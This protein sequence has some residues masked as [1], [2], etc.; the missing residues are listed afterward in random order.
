MTEITKQYKDA[1]TLDGRLKPQA[2]VTK[3]KVAAVKGLVESAL[4]GSAISAGT[5]KETMTTSDAIFAFAYLTNLNFIPQYDAAPRT[6]NQVAGTFKVSDFRP[7]TLYSLTNQWKAGVLGDG[8]PTHVA[9]VVPEGEPYPY[10][11]LAGSESASGGVT[12]RG[13]KTDFTFEAFVNDPVGF[14]QALPGEMLQVAL[15]TEEFVVYNALISGVGATEKLV[16]GVTADG[17]TVAANSPISRAAIARAIFELSQRKINGRKIV[18]NGG[19]NVI[20]APGQGQIVNFILNQTYSELNDGSFVMNIS[21]YN[22]LA[23]VSVVESEYVIGDDW[24]LVPKPGSTR[25][26]VLDLGLLVGH[27]TPEIR[28]ENATGNYVGGGV[29]APFEGS[30]DTDSATFRLRQINGGLLWFK[31]HIIWSNGSGVA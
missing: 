8:N 14:I 31:Q 23:S 9:P 17:T 12:K 18:V 21:G 25:R 28:V 27:E 4:H 15:D 2:G 22:P 29:V 20:V 24:Y 6:W 11:Y 13:F 26:R 19:F 16:G 7:A 10:A 1:F 5:L 30:F 3:A